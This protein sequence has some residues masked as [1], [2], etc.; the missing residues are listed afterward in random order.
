[1]YQP[2]VR[3][4]T[5]R[6]FRVCPCHPQ[7]ERIVQEQIGQH[8]ADHAALRRATG[9]LDPRAVLHAHRCGQPPFDVQNRPWARHM[10][11]NRPQQKR[12]VDVVEQALDVEFQYPVVVPAALSRHADG[13]ERRF[14]G[15]IAVGIRQKYRLQIRFNHPFD[16]HLCHTIGHGWHPQKPLPATLFRNGD[17]THR[18]R[19]VASRAHPVPEFVE[20]VSQLGFEL[21]DRLSI[22]PGPTGIG[23]D[24][25][26]GF[27]N[28]LLIDTERLVCCAHRVLLLPVASM[29]QPA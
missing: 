4:P 29:M 11:P 3:I 6:K 25:L 26:V 14:T 23:P 21:L 15:P 12:M 10:F 9:S 2:I 28:Q 13:I 17:G 22:H 24:R 27:V 1:M 16:N 18:W 20:V 5:P 19:K 7:I 8:G